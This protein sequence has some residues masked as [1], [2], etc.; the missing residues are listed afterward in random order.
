MIDYIVVNEGL[1]DRIL[2]FKIDVRVDSNHL[3]LRRFIENLFLRW[4]VEKTVEGTVH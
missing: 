3:L 4:K 1:S 2:E